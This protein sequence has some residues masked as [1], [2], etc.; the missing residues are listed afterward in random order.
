[1]HLEFRIF[2][3]PVRIRVWFVFMAFALGVLHPDVGSSGARL[4]AFM[5]VL[6]TAVLAHELGHAVAGK[7]YGWVPRIELG[8]IGGVTYFERRTQVSRGQRMLLVAL[9]PLVGAALG[10]VAYATLQLSPPPPDSLAAFALRQTQMI[11]LVWGL[12]NLVP[13]LPL[14]GGHLVAELASIVSPTRGRRFAAWFSIVLCLVLGSLAAMIEAWTM[15]LVAGLFAFRNHRILEVE[16][17]GYDPATGIRAR[18]LAYVALT[19]SDA[20]A[21]VEFALRARDEATGPEESDEASYL[22]AWGRFLGGDPRGAR[23]ALDASSGTRTRDF[24]LE[25]AIAH[26]LGELD[27]S[28]E[29]FERSLP[30]ATPFIEPRMVHAIVATRRFDEAVA[31]F[32]D[33]L[34]ASFSP[35]SLASVQ[36]A[37]YDAGAD[38]AAIGIGQT[39]FS[40]T[41]DA[42]VAFLLACSCSRVGRLEDAFGWLRRARDGGFRKADALDSEPALAALRQMPEWGELRASFGR[43]RA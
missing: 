26:D 28:L 40:R 39:L 7:A 23:A 32:D 21:V 13:I 24:A 17:R 2:E 1:M 8:F 41:P 11:N 6:A 9:G 29:L 3:I 35:R 12:L 27:R 14:D 37:A 4:V 31:L 42:S 10:L 25:G 34:G 38:G 5:L 16:R 15:V 43:A 30:R 19:R 36:R 22:L 33:E 20:A 18:D